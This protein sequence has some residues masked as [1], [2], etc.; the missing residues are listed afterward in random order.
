MI[1]SIVHLQLAIGQLAL[2]EAER[3]SD[4][5]ERASQEAGAALEAHRLQQALVHAEMPV[6]TVHPTV[7]DTK[8]KQASAYVQMALMQRVKE[9]TPTSGGAGA[10]GFGVHF[11]GLPLDRVARETLEAAPTRQLARAF[12]ELEHLARQAE[13]VASRVHEFEAGRRRARENDQWQAAD[14][15]Q[16]IA[17][18]KVETEQQTRIQSQSKAIGHWRARLSCTRSIAD[19]WLIFSCLPLRRRS[20]RPASAVPRLSGS[21]RTP[22]T[23]RRAPPADLAALPG[24]REVRRV[25][26]WLRE[27]DGGG[28]RA[29]RRDIARSTGR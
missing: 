3:E 8:E 10:D 1:E 9:R 25:Q 7:S 11:S 28:A 2:D 14:E 20:C 23:A 18:M 15:A 13:D 24:Q 12:N 26:S 16:A 19:A 29:A 17:R 4:A 5:L 27:G 22:G 21:R 6:P